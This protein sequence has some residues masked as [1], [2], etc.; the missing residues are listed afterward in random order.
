MK[1]YIT[2]ADIE[3]TVRLAI[4]NVA[5]KLNIEDIDWKSSNELFEEI[6]ISEHSLFTLLDSYL[7]N[8]MAWVAFIQKHKDRDD[9]NLEERQQLDKLTTNRNST[10]TALKNAITT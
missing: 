8:Y 7:L 2:Q 4:I 1:I 3:E 9:Y 10:R 5:R 6:K